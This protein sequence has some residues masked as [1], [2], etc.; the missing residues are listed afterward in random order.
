MIFQTGSKQ[1][2]GSRLDSLVERERSN[3]VQIIISYLRTKTGED[4]GNDPEKWIEK[5]AKK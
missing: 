3:A 5:Y 1:I 4:L 2:Q